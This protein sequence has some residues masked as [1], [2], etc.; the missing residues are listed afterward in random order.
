MTSSQQYDAIVIGS[1][2]AGTP[3]STA[4]AQAGMRTAL[5]EREQVG[6]TCVNEGCTP[7][8]TMVAS[9]RV[10]YLARRAADYGVHTGPISIDL[11]KVRQRKRDIVSSFRNGSQS[12][13][14][15]AANLELIFG[16]A[17]FTGPKSVEV[18]S[19]D[20]GQHVI[21][22]KYIFINAG[23]RA[24]RPKLAGLDDVQFLDNRSIM[25]LD[26]VPEH[27][28]VLGGGYIGLEF[29]QLFRR[30]G[31]RV[32]IIQSAGQLLAGE[33]RDI[34]D[35]VAKI[36]RQDGVEILL[37]AKATRVGRSDGN[38]RLEVQEQGNSTTL[39]GSHLLIA[40]GRVPNSDTLNLP[41]ADIQMNDRGFIQVN[42][43]LET[44][45]DGVYALGDIKGGPAF[46]HISYDDFRIIRANLLENK[47]AGKKTASIAN[48]LVPYTLFI[49]PQLGRVGLTETEARAQNRNIR[50]AKLP[51]TSVARAREVDETR[52]FMKVVVDGENNQILGAAILGIEG[53]E[54]MAALEIA[55]M[56]K[57]S[58]TELRDGVF[59]HPTLA[60]SLNNLFM[61]MDSNK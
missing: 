15:K 13:I 8:K 47:A 21:S 60:E 58:Y 61:A 3:L 38:I 18:R 53:G 1:G 29:G 51:M 6:G 50:V 23:T 27:L 41:A 52:G 28:L 54:V 31:S 49:D 20:G 30:F 46:T 36:L 32:T 7:T 22:A 19:K 16:S 39:A 17:S 33:D 44:T 34:A 10:A 26:T 57:L 25:E 9:G 59:A 56:G 45:V 37:K 4:L 55:M 24:S 5:I 48:R 35:E 40:T 14:E 12:R 42:D 11:L 2:Q 43:R